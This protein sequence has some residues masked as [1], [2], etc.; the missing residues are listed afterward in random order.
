MPSNRLGCTRSVSVY[1]SILVAAISALSVAGCNHVALHSPTILSPGSSAVTSLPVKIQ[2]RMNGENLSQL[3]IVLNGAVI[4]SD[5]TESNGI[6]T[7]TMNDGV[8]VGDN[9]LSVMP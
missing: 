5:F 1:A 4:T 8:Y 9:R 7:A 6:A 2:L 3:K